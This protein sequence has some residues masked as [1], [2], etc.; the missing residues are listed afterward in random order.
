MSSLATASGKIIVNPNVKVQYVQSGTSSVTI[1]T[2]TE[3]ASQGSLLAPQ[4][5]QNVQEEIQVTPTKV[6]I[7]IPSKPISF[8]FINPRVIGVLIGLL[9]LWVYVRGLRGKRK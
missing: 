1:A 4:N 3:E 6:I 9:F 2:P 5:Q 8:D 7:Q